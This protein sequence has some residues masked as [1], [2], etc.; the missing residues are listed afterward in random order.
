MSARATALAAMLAVVALVSGCAT[1]SHEWAPISGG[2]VNG[3]ADKAYRRDLTAIL[4]ADHLERNGSVMSANPHDMIAADAAALK[5]DPVPVPTAPPG[6]ETFDGKWR[7]ARQTLYLAPGTPG[8]SGGVFHVSGIQSKRIDIALADFTGRGVTV[9]MSCDGR[10]SRYGR[11]AMRQRVAIPAG[12]QG[13][14]LVTID[15]A[16]TRCEAVAFFPGKGQRRYVLEREEAGNNGLAAADERYDVCAAAPDG[17]GD[18][19]TQVFMQARW[20]SQTCAFDPGRVR[21]LR[22]ERDAFNGKVEVLLGRPLPSSFY[23]KADAFAPIDFSHAP[24]LSTIY[25]SYLDIKADFS[26]KVLDRLLRYHA[27]RGAVIRVI[28]SDI[29]LRD[30]DRVLMERLAADYPN[31][32]LK[33]FAWKAPRRSGLKGKIVEALRVHHVKMLAGLSPD[34]GRSSVVIGSRNIHDGFLFK[35]PVDMSAHP[36]LNQYRRTGGM[37]LNY[38]SNW[39]DFDLAIKDEKAVRT[40]A[41]HM[42]TFWN[43]DAD[44]WV[45]RPMSVDGKARRGASGRGLMRHFISVPYADGR[46]L[47]KLYVDLFDAARDRIE[48]VNPYLNFTD[49][50]AAAFDRALNR[51]VKV[52]IV[53]RINLYGDLAGSVLTELNTLFLER[54]GSRITFREYRDPGVL[55][56]SKIL[57]VDEELVVVSSVNLNNRSFVLDTENGVMMLDRDFYRRMKQVFDY[58]FARAEPFTTEKASAFWKAVLSIPILREAM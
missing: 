49:D 42:A 1:A 40:L 5:G 27:A 36:E 8:D 30:K 46:A 17:A 56:H 39:T 3:P 6:R 21:T 7:T 13:P 43:A 29:L 4:A 23:D 52:T 33:T 51:G 22:D 37:T 2:V 34:P 54:Y 47:E 35:D 44:T 12:A 19:L 38:Y 28:T 11:G 57:M 53:G 48:I 32:E 9:E 25:V 15:P 20:L 14:T 26:G 58:Y 45:A 50:L 10:V 16:V 18:S 41:A 24:R 55:L 31:V